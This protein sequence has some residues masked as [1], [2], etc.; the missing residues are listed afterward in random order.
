MNDRTATRSG[1]TSLEAAFNKA[2]LLRKQGDLPRAEQ[3]YR[4][5]LKQRPSHFGTLCRL[6]E[7][8]TATSRCEEAVRLLRKSL[9]QVPNSAE[10][11]TLLA[12]ALHELERD[13]EAIERARRAVALNPRSAEA[14]AALAWGLVYLGRYDEALRAQTRAIELAPDQPRYYYHWGYMT[15]WTADDPRLSALEALA[16]K[17]GSMTLDDQAHLNLALAKAYADCGDMER[18]FRRQIEGNALMRRTFQYDEPSTLRQ[19][20]ELRLAL[21]AEWMGSHLGVGDPS[22]LPVFIVGMPRSGTTLVEQILASHPEV[23]ALGERPHFRSALAQICGAD[24]MPTSIASLA[25]RLSDVELRRL[26]SLY[27]EAAR[28]N[29]SA[30]AARII[31]KVPSNF[32]FAGLIH[33]AL[34]HARIIHIC[35]DPVETCLSQFSIIFASAAVPYSYDLGELGRYYGAYR[36]MMAHWDAVLPAGVMIDVQYEELVDD[37]ER[38]ARRIVAHCGLEWNDACLAFHKTERPVRTASHAQVRQP[39]Y[40]SSIG[41]Q[42]PSRDLLLPLLEALGQD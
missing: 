9:N 3:L 23:H 20:D 18:A 17:S 36:K 4:D 40:R 37:L 32:R 12:L 7:L 13:E 6:A 10:A 34:P 11:N 33:A 5:I 31:D 39:I 38:Q 24:A 25:A 22:P 21:D 1:G 15:R 16:R 8:L 2:G 29:A 19:L 42:R 35:R 27:V 26:G 14:H 41:R 28:R 30:T